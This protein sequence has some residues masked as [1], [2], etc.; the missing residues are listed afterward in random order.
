MKTIN[1]NSWHYKFIIWNFPYEPKNICEYF[2][3]LFLSFLISP[4][5]VL[6]NYYIKTI[7]IHIDMVKLEET[8]TVR[9]SELGAILFLRFLITILFTLL[10]VVVTTIFTTQVLY[11]CAAVFVYPVIFFGLYKIL[12]SIKSKICHPIDY[13]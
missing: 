11:L 1:K 12:K 8:T 7:L 2:T 4:F 5:T 10:S 9:R 3:F 6:E 13:V